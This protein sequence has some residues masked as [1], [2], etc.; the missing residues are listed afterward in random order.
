MNKQGNKSN[1]SGGIEWTH[2]FGPGT[3]YTANPV[4]GCQHACRWRMPD[5][6]LAICYA[7]AVA[8]RFPGKHYAR[9]F[10]VVSFDPGE[11]SAIQMLKTPAGI[12]ID[13]MSDLFAQAV[14]DD[15]INGVLSTIRRCPKHVFFSLTKNPTRLPL[16]FRDTPA[17]KNLFLGVSMPPTFMFGKELTEQQQRTWFAKALASLVA[18]NAAVRW[19][20]LEPLSWDCSDILSTYVSGLNWA[21]IGAASDGSKKFQPEQRTLANVLDA[22]RPLPVFFKGNLRDSIGQDFVCQHWRQEFP[23]H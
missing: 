12:F 22:L 1:P 23:K 6:K 17:P 4:R 3:G 5:G 11:L 8:E 7:E 14:P 10:G 9:G 18:S 15:W 2:I 21:V 16:W 19:V 20:S 13:S